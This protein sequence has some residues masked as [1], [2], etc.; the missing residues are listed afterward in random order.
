MVWQ[1][2]RFKDI[3]K[4]PN[5]LIHGGARGV[6]QM[7]GMFGI[8]CGMEVVEFKADW[9]RYGKRAGPIRNQQMLDDG[10]PDL[11][12]AFP[13]GGGTADMVRRS[14]ARGVPVIEI[15]SR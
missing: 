11:V 3:P 15:P 10:Q 14:K 2:N 8:G 7:A 1:R 6:D 9:N 4:Q 5:V 13:G 12:V